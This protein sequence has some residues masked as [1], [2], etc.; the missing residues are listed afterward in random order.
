MD[1]VVLLD[2]AHAFVRPASRTRPVRLGLR[3]REREAGDT[4]AVLA[5]GRERERAPTAADLEHVVV[6]PEPELVADE[7]ELAA[8]RVGE[9][10]VFAFED[11]A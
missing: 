7:P 10:L 6:G 5:C 8:L 3:R 1:A 9:R 11:R 4:G 2:D